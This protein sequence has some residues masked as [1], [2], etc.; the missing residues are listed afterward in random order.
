MAPD[1]QG[2]GHQPVGNLAFNDGITAAVDKLAEQLA[3]T[4]FSADVLS[5]L[6]RRFQPGARVAAAFAG[7]I[8]DLLSRH[9]L[10]VFESNDP[11]LKPLVADLFARELDSRAVSRLARSGADAMEKLGHTPQVV[12]AEDAVALFYVDGAGR[13]A[14]RARGTELL[15]GD[16]ARSVADLKA[17]AL[18]HP[19]R[20]SP[21]VL[22][23]PLVQDRLFP[24][25][26]YVSGPAELAYHAQLGPAYREFGVEEPL[27]YSRASASL[28][29]GAAMRF[30]ER[31]GLAL[32]SLNGKDESVLNQWLAHQL[33][34]EL[35]RG[36]D[37]M[38]ALVRDRVEAL[39]ASV[40]TID[41]TL[42]GAV[43][44]TRDKMRETLKTLHG[45]II[46]AAKRK[47]DTLRR[48]FVRTRAL[49]FP[50]GIPQERS[51]NVAFFANRYGLNFADTLLDALPL[52]TDKHYI[53]T[54]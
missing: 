25:I 33:P 11:A 46:Q 45:K 2:A 5:T 18:A 41:P 53:L 47:D 7:W 29:D 30:F 17:E 19:E 49:T 44:T 12:P 13:R 21:N 22:L 23:R 48:Q 1:I 38:D 10:V 3:P 8:D 4:E 24:T 42:A 26:C 37:E 20:F 43:D 31:S 14:I 28:V 15:I 36:I 16:S 50:D 52:E 6:R 9:G 35:E 34:A 39:K 40:S 32:E 54:L 27:L 51:L